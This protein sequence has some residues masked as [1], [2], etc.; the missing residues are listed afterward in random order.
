VSVMG[1]WAGRS[2]VCISSWNTMRDAPM[3]R[4]LEL[5]ELALMA[6]NPQSRLFGAASLNTVE[7][8]VVAALGEETI[9]GQSS[10]STLE[11]RC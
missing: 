2:A 6:S 5:F 9:G 1:V 8:W 10:D 4:H 3:S 7:P 11:R